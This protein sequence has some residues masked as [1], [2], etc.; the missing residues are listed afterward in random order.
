MKTFLMQGVGRA[1]PAFAELGTTLTALGPHPGL[2]PDAGR[3]E[4]D[5]SEKPWETA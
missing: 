1:A 2:T 3:V 5:G 4:F